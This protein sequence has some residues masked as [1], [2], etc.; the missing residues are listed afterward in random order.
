MKQRTHLRNDLFYTF[1]IE[2]TTIITGLDADKNPIRNAIV[3]SA[4]FY[5]GVDYIQERNLSSMIKRLKLI[6]EEKS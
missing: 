1:D 6:E 3:W 5:D 4:Q 2:T